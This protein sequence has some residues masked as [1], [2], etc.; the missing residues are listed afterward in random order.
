VYPNLTPTLLVLLA[1]AFGASLAIALRRPFLRHLAFRQVSRR[2]REAAL[3]I[4]GSMLGTAIV[5]GSLIVGD[6]LNFSVKQAAYENLGP[7]DETVMSSSPGQG[8]LAANRLAAIRSDPAVDGILTAHGDVA[9]VSIGSGAGRVAEPRVGVWD[10]DF[11]LA[12]AFGTAGG[13]ASGLTG[14]APPAGQA[15]INTDLASALG[16]TRGDTLTF[17]L[18][19]SP[20]QVRVARVVETVGLAGMSIDAVTRDAF[21]APGTLF[22]A[23]GAAG[24]HAATQPRTFTF[25]SNAGDVESG[26]DLSAAVAGKIRAALGSLATTGT[27]VETSKKTVLAEAQL[28]GD[29]LGTMFLMIGSF[30]IIA[31]I[32]LLVNIFVMLAEERKPELGML[33]AVGMRRSRLVRSF[34]LE[35]S[36]YAV[37]AALLG[38]VVGIGVGRAV[39]VVAARIYSG[40]DVAGNA[41]HVV[42]HVTPVSLVNGF[43]IGLL[44]ALVT[45]ALTSI[46]ISRINIIAAIRDL[47]PVEGRRMKRRWVIVSAAL[48]AVFGALSVLAIADDNGIGA[49]VFPALAVICLGPTLL[50][51]A[52]KRLV[53][54]G[55]A[56]AVIAWTLLANTVRPHI[57]DAGGTGPFIFIGVLLTFSAVLLVSQNQEVVT[58]P[59]RPL[60]DRASQLGLSTR[61]AVAYPLGKRFRTG[62]ILIMYGLVIF[63]LVFI[64]ILAALIDGTVSRQVASASGGY[65]LRVDF[66]PAAPIANP[67]RTF[68]TGP[69]L[70]KVAVVTQLS[71]ARGTVTDLSAMVPDPVD[72]V[73]VSTDPTILQMGGFPLAK[74]AAGFSSD[75][76]AWNALFSD[77]RYAIVDNFL[78]QLNAGGPPKDFLRPGDV[79]TLTDPLTGKVEHKTIAG[80]LDS[81]FAFYGMGGGLYSPIVLSREAAT[82]QFGANLRP[83]SALVKPADGV[84]DAALAAQLQGR[85]LPQGLS[86]TIIRRAV[87]QNYSANRGFFQL[88]QGFVALGLLVGVAGL[89]VVMVRA[90]RERRRSIGVLR[91]LGFPSRTVQRAFLTESLFV[92]LEGVFL[93]TVLSIITTYMLFKN[94]DLF[95]TAQG[96]SIPWLTIVV[97]V[98]LATAA[99]VL[100]TIWP[101]R[102]ASRVKPAVALRM[103]E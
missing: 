77:P 28:T 60:A 62:A 90:V 79:F 86:A 88:M 35:G 47:P 56:L 44:I 23:A 71:A 65:G 30:A 46:R 11:G 103:G 14:P 54:S 43:A 12:A 3:V 32:L 94:Y 64:T 63:T 57:L 81:S 97:L 15:V 92:T 41:L 25:V 95:Q 58:A 85:Y 72:A 75:Q 1:V 8:L 31:G 100:A 48:A 96:F 98:A 40:F 68:A 67:A 33:R 74:R 78:G 69:L 20:V 2:R 45:V 26:N 7:I 5:V 9:A 89:G 10:V 83:V 101:A 91:A 17:Y 49:Y 70:G 82:Q 29:S 73:I 24:D 16:A 84:S 87:E 66:N 102:Q 53:Y 6:T 42:F 18:Y 4:L 38:T 21:F 52:P 22:R 37:I 93:G 99:S 61:L 51:L 76:E 36:V 59:L 27:S 13:N 50:R 39:V 34:Y 55:T 80:T 19:G